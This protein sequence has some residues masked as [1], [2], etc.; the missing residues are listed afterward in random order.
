[1]AAVPVRAFDTHAFVKRLT[2]AGMPEPQAEILAD[3]QS[4]LIDDKR[5]TKT[6]LRETGRLLESN[7]RE[8]AL[9]LETK[10]EAVKADLVKWMFGMVGF[11]TLLILG[12]VIALARLL[13]P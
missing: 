7:I 12:A 8:T 1:M 4:K 2:A 3:E 6:D 11:Q 10:I 9:R 5:V 13:H